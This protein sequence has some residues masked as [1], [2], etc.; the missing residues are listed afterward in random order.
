MNAVF[1]D[2]K[3]SVLSSTSSF[4]FLPSSSPPKGETKSRP[5]PKRWSTIF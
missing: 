5:P 3:H 4:S 2:R 1:K